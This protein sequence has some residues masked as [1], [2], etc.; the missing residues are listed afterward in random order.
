[1]PFNFV[2]GDRT[3]PAGEYTF[4]LVQTGGSDSV[5]IQSADG[6]ITTFVLTRAARAKAWQSEPKVVFNRYADQYFLSQVYGLGDSTTQ[7][8]AKPRVE[9]R[10]AKTAAEKKDV[11]ITAHKR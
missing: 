11:S 7:Q 6:H 5:K 10:L 8:L 9:D 3:L 1:V 2:V 4:M